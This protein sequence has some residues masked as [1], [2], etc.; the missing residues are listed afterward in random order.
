MSDEPQNQPPEEQQPPSQETEVPQQQQEPTPEQQ[1]GVS[2][3]T[4]PRQDW[5]D[6]RIGEQQQRLRERNARIQQLEAQLAAVAGQ[7]QPGY[8]PDP[9]TGYPQQQPAYAQPVGDIQ[10]QI[11]EA[12]ARM[13]AGQEFNRRCNEVAEL[14]RRSYQNFDGRVQRLTGLID[15][16]DPMQVERYNGFL[17]ACMQTGQASRLIYELGGNLDEASRI[18]AQDPVGMTYELTKMSMRNGSDASGA[19]RP[20]NPVATA[21]QSDRR[22]IQ[23][24]DPDNADGLTTEEW[25]RR[26]DEQIATRRQRTLG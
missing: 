22:M 8:Q 5:R 15:P 20:L 7:T 10:Q 24:D 6:R 16:N 18:M 9:A 21:A 19:P 25:M 4:E 23:P 13:A 26:R 2:R 14:G 11:N 1:E 17:R 12:A 3:E